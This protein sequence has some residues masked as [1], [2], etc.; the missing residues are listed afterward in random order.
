MIS[1]QECDVNDMIKTLRCCMLGDKQDM[2]NADFLYGIKSIFIC[3][4][5]HVYLYLVTH[6]TISRTTVGL[7]V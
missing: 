3:E 6:F 5:M 4:V 7:Y 1:T 2:Q